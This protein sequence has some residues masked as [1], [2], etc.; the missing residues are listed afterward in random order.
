MYRNCILEESNHF[1]INSIW[2][3]FCINIEV[4]NEKCDFT[5]KGG[6]ELAEFHVV[7]TFYALLNISYEYVFIQIFRIQA[8]ICSQ[9]KE[10]EWQVKQQ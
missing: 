2:I 10:H 9:M 6:C 3:S 1:T 7:S 8:F 5:D 4:K